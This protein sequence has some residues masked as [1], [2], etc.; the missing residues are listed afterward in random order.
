MSL[1]SFIPRERHRARNSNRVDWLVA[2][3]IMLR[4]TDLDWMMERNNIMQVLYP[5]A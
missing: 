1:S 5:H 4:D 2:A 3:E